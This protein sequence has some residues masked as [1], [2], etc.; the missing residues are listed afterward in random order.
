M[1]LRL[2]PLTGT[3]TTV[4]VSRW[5]DGLVAE[6]LKVMLDLPEQGRTI[7]VVTLVSVL[8]W[9]FAESRTLR[10]ETLTIPV[11]RSG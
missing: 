5:L 4:P 10:V 6:V 7:L 11:Q 1:L 9:F 8:V 3:P 2:P